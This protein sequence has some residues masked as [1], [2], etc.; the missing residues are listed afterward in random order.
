MKKRW[1]ILACALLLCTSILLGAC[2]NKTDGS[3]DT[4]APSAPTDD[5]VVTVASAG[6]SEYKIVTPQGASQSV[7]DAA[8]ALRNAIEEKCGVKLTW[9]DDYVK[10]GQSVPTDTKEIL[11]GATNRA[12]SADAAELVFKVRDCAFLE[13][14]NQIALVAG[15]DEYLKDAVAAF[16]A[17][18]IEGNT[19]SLPRGEARVSP[20]EYAVEALT[21]QGRSI[22][23]FCMY[24][25]DASLQK[26]AKALQVLIE[27]KVGYRVEIVKEVASGAPT[28]R[29]CTPSDTA[30]DVFSAGIGAFDIGWHMSDRDLI[31]VSGNAADATQAV[32]EFGKTYLSGTEKKVNIAG[33]TETLFSTKPEYMIDADTAYLAGLQQKADTLKD[34][35]IASITDISGRTGT[36]YYVS[37]NGNDL[38]D[39]RSP[40]T[41]WATIKKV[42]SVSLGK[43][44]AVL[45]ERGGEWRGNI[46][47]NGG[48]YH[49]LS[50]VLFGNYGN[51]DDPLPI[52]NGSACNY[53]DASLWEATD[54]PNVWKL[55]LPLY[56]V[57]V[58][59]F[60]HSGELGDYDAQYGKILF[61][62]PDDSA[63]FGKRDYQPLGYRDL[64][65]DLQFYS[66]LKES[67]TL[68]LYSAEGNPGERFSSIE[69]GIDEV[70][71]NVGGNGNT[72]DGIHFRFCGGFAVAGGQ[73][74]NVTVRNCIMEWIGGSV[75]PSNGEM[76][77]GNAIQIY[78]E[79]RGFTVENNWIYQIYDTGIT[80]QI[81]KNASE[82]CYYDNINIKNNLV[83][84][85]H[86]GIEFYN[87]PRKDGDDRR[88]TKNVLI[89]GNIV[90]TGGMGWGSAWR[91]EC[92]DANTVKGAS[93][94][95]LCSWGLTDGTENFVIRNNILDRCTGEL[96]LVTMPNDNGD[97]KIVYEGN[98]YI[99][100]LNQSFGKI[101]SS[102]YSMST[103]TWMTMTEV[104]L[105][106]NGTLAFIEA[107]ANE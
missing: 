2:K 6:I 30:A 10:R 7:N 54:A 73:S 19:V 56:N 1:I 92:Y 15:E 36:I 76:L 101:F 98:T 28:I 21:L 39:G 12:L 78:G 79:V 48:G 57:G 71:L 63:F 18:Y 62:D 104:L 68:Y 35:V 67:G 103:A 64:T 20:A 40:E 87:Q 13:R 55:T 46:I 77:Y 31:L 91:F 25:A 75:H 100:E 70:M 89:E 93:A 9:E 8:V 52:L 41:A 66:E 44:D 11:I 23:T 45:F 51:V 61:H 96:G 83:E 95:L 14:N 43:G 59:V 3:E 16:S 82:N 105:D 4:T 27:D 102:Y 90:R 97:R 72:V 85:C 47:R 5:S 37:N 32:A 33:N 60:D 74:S 26:Y 84:Y 38:A 65:D 94:A 17:L 24:V 42:N 107:T 99:Q 29:F 86:W 69:I 80:F 106:Q 49:Y 34:N 58:M 81:S 53:A 50:E 88:T 22:D